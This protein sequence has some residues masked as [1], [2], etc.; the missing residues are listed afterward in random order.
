MSSIDLLSEVQCER[1]SQEHYESCVL[2]ALQ[3]ESL[4]NASEFTSSV[5]VTYEGS[6]LEDKE[7]DLENL[8]GTLYENM[9]PSKAQMSMELLKESLEKL[10][11]M[12]KNAIGRLLRATKDF[13]YSLLKGTKGMLK[14]VDKLRDKVGAVRAANLQPP[15]QPITITSGSRLHMGGTISAAELTDGIENGVVILSQTKGL[16][17]E[18]AVGLVNDL[19]KLTDRLMKVN[20][21]TADKLQTE[22]RALSTYPSQISVDMDSLLKGMRSRELPGGKRVEVQLTEYTPRGIPKN[23]PDLS[24]VDFQGRVSYRERDTVL[25]PDLDALTEIL[26]RTEELVK[27]MID[28]N[29]RAEALNNRYERVVE[30]AEDMF[31]RQSIMGKLKE[32]MHEHTVELLM[33]FYQMGMP[34]ALHRLAKYEFS[35]ARATLAYVN[36]SLNSYETPR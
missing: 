15:T 6:S 32:F 7:S 33:R 1:R 4:T 36:D 19:E 30:R 26:D 9:Y 14:K 20:D 12:I 35:V 28:S 21:Q 10:W 2:A 25:A 17:L 11:Q 18:G 29:E 31:D 8:F 16:Y 27:T 22:I 34:T 5:L 13:F 23:M 24:L 3:L